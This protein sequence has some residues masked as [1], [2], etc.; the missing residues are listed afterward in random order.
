MRSLIGT[1]QLLSLAS[2]A[3]ADIGFAAHYARPYLPSA[4]YGN[5]QSKFPRDSMFAAVGDGLWDNGASCGRKYQVRCLSSTSGCKTGTI[6]VQIVDHAPANGGGTP[7]PSAPRTAL[8]LSDAAFQKIANLQ[9]S[10]NIEYVP[11]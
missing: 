3:V 7:K 2:I 9:T 4:C 5:D 6:T 1:L 8:V 10:I 11:A